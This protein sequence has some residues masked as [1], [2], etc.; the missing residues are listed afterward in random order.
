MEF[1]VRATGHIAPQLFLASRETSN[2]SNHSNNNSSGIVIAF[3]PA[4]QKRKFEIS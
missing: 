4:A 2:F 3:L 1:W